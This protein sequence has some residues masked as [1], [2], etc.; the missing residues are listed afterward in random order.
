MLVNPPDADAQWD[1]RRAAAE[2]A[3]EA[4]RRMLVARATGRQ[5]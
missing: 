3:L 4:A 5:K 2:N 1:Y